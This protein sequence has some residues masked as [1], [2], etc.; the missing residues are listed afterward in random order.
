[1][2]KARKTKTDIDQDLFG[3]SLNVNKRS[4]QH[5]FLRDMSRIPANAAMLVAQNLRR[6]YR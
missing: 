6:W 1:M 2:W 3:V 4:A 5:D